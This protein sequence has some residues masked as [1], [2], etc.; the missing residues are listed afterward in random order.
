M[1]GI[2]KGETKQSRADGEGAPSNRLKRRHKTWNEAWRKNDHLQDFKAKEKKAEAE[3]EEETNHAASREEERDGDEALQRSM[4]GASIIQQLWIMGQRAE[5]AVQ[6]RGRERRRPAAS[7][8]VG[9]PVG[10]VWNAAT[11]KSS[12]VPAR[13]YTS[14][15]SHTEADA[16]LRS[17]ENEQGG[18]TDGKHEADGH[19]IP[20]SWSQL[21]SIIKSSH[22]NAQSAVFFLISNIK[23]QEN[24]QQTSW[25]HVSM[26]QSSERTCSSLPPD[27]WPPQSQL[28]SAERF[29]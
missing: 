11:R 27:P 26:P 13:F 24:Q 6:I 20:T 18:N 9:D 25:T 12:R 4:K 17:Q 3:T 8:P 14:G 23:H 1:G 22:L 5:A 28:I 2:I 19:L 7:V 15:R 16:A 10:G 21:N 29:I